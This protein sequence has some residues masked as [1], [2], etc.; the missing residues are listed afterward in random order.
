[1]LSSSVNELVQSLSELNLS[2][3]ANLKKESS[4]P[5]FT[6]M[7]SQFQSDIEMVLIHYEASKCAT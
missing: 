7:T 5:I 1:M 2:S 3:V 4:G 6:N